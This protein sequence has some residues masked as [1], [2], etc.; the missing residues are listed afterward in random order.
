MELSELQAHL[1][2]NNPA[3]YVAKLLKGFKP[4]FKYEAYKHY[5]VIFHDVM[6]PI[7][8]ANK[9]IKKPTGVKLPDG[10]DVLEDAIV[11]VN[12]TALP[13]QKFIV[14][15]LATFLTGGKV[16]FKCT[17]EGATEQAMFDRVKKLW[18]SNKLH[19]KNGLLAE[20]MMSQTE[21][22]ELWFTDTV[23]KK[24]KAGN[25]TEKKVLKMNVLRPSDGFELQPF[26]DEIGNLIAFGIKYKK[27]KVDY[28]D[29]YTD[30]ELRKH[31][32]VNGIWALVGG[33]EGI[34]ELP[35]GKMPIIYF[36][37]DKSEWYDVQ[38]LIERLEKMQSN[39]GD[40][41]DYSGS[42]ILFVRGD[43]QG[44]AAKGEPGK[45]LQGGQDA[46]AEYLMPD[47]APESV[48]QEFENLKAF[49]HLF[50]GAPDLSLQAL[51]GLG[52]IPSGAAFERLLILTYMKVRRRQVGDWGL[53]IQRRN[54]FLVS[55]LA[56]TDTTLANAEDLDIT[57]DWGLYKLNDLMDA[58]NAAI[59]ANGGL[60]IIS[61]EES[62]AMAALTDD[63]EETFNKIKA[64]QSA[65]GNIIDPT[66]GN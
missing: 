33:E 30:T 58:I 53:L 43:I 46:E 8:R 42:P 39:H 52:Q 45:V 16:E 61:Q 29:L 50:T 1:S 6:S 17:P 14:E 4:Y 40:T 34:I 38:S 36:Q 48:K 26:Y 3:E 7:K 20:A 56:N 54:N 21:V 47:S 2:G 22:A 27:D 51:K 32:K 25:Q 60:P 5:D 64:E 28:Y 57:V 18:S 59:A 9:A 13:F 66:P 41:N 19:F 12:R 37:Q 55:A 24:D 31:Q 44:F 62:V 63:P 23:V 35:Y 49:I 15:T 10:T 65:I 11:M